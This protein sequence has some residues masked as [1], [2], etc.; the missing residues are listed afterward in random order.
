MSQILNESLDAGGCGFSAQRLGDGFVSVQ[1]D[2]DGTPMVTDTMADEDV[3]AFGRVLKERGEGFIQ[4]TQSS[5]D[6]EADMRFYD[7]LADEC[8]R[9]DSVQCHRPRRDDRPSIH[10]RILRWMEKTNKAGRKIYNQTATF[11][12]RAVLQLCRYVGIV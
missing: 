5:P 3:L 9:P 10:R 2:Y 1:R 7:R 4:L 12:S 8:G 6:F 11:P